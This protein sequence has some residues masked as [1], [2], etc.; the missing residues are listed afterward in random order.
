MD[1]TFGLPYCALAVWVNCYKRLPSILSWPVGWDLPI[2]WELCGNTLICIT[3]TNQNA[4]FQPIR[5]MLF[6]TTSIMVFWFLICIKMD[7][8]GNKVGTFSL[9]SSFLFILV[10]CIFNFP[11][12][13]IPLVCKLFQMN[14]V[15]SLS[16][17]QIGDFVNTKIGDTLRCLA[18]E[19][20]Q[21]LS[22]PWSPRSYTEKPSLT[23]GEL[24]L[25][26]TK[27]NK[28]STINKKMRIRTPR[29]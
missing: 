25:K 18:K 10:K 15:S 17:L 4:R 19:N 26:I 7:Q 6:G 24:K 22:Q 28:W 8:S 14:K 1:W 2:Q 21:L 23:K 3:L 5:T 27:N 9:K 11:G 29:T 16:T 12:G 20:I 13:C